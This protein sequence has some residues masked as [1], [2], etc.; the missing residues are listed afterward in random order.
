M[1]ELGAEAGRPAGPPASAADFDSVGSQT[2]GAATSLVRESGWCWCAVLR[3]GGLVVLAFARACLARCLPWRCGLRG[4]RLGGAASLA[5]AADALASPR[6]SASVAAASAVAVAAG[7]AAGRLAERSSAGAAT[8]SAVT[9]S[10]VTALARQAGARPGACPQPGSAWQRPRRPA[11][12]QR[13]TPCQPARAA[14]RSTWSASSRWRVK[15]L[16]SQLALRATNCSA[17]GP[18]A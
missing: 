7:A 5:W 15:C 18:A 14:V 17:S 4:A 2:D 12:W 8:S 9:A 16:V 11:G 6:P 1:L 10:S 13:G 3:R